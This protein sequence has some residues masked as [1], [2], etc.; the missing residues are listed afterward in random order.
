MQNPWRV[1]LVVAS[2]TIAQNA[3]AAPYHYVDWLTASVSGGT[4]SGTITLPDASVVTVGFQAITATGGPGN[5]GPATQTGC[6][7]NYW[8]P[9]TPYVSAQVSNPPPAC[10][11]VAL[12][13]G[14]NQTYIVTLSEAIKD[15]I[16]A[17]LSLGQP[18]V[19]T[20]YDFDSPFDIVSQGTGFW[21]GTSSSLAELPNDILRGNEGHGTIQFI[22]TFSTFSWVVP[23]PENWHGFTFGIRT[24]ER[25][26]PDPPAAVPEPASLLLL[27]GG[28]AAGG[29]RSHYARKRSK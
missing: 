11:I 6:G 9:S 23:T 3:S 16:M 1:L 18:S 29:V 8:N 7:T 14:V 24:T 13:G 4:A 15:P 20:T 25:I 17:V 2:L 26:E 19:F 5:L 10:D 12:I 21:G 27:V 22:G 28:L